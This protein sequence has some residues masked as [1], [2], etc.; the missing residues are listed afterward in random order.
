[1]SVDPTKPLWDPEPV[2]E[3]GSGYHPFLN[4]A[5]A[6]IAAR[7]AALEDDLCKRAEELGYGVMIIEDFPGK[8]LASVG[9]VHPSVPPRSLHV[10]KWGPYIQSVL[11]PTRVKVILDQVGF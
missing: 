10:H 2:M 1:M 5:V 3:L 7:R 8:P 11:G 6:D 4:R 9:M